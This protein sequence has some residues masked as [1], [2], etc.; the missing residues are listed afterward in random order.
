M[1]PW[2]NKKATPMAS[3]NAFN[4]ISGRASVG[5]GLYPCPR[6]C[7]SP[8]ILPGVSLRAA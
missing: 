6:P 2:R 4:K 8:Q 7:F 1:A 3:F 5:A